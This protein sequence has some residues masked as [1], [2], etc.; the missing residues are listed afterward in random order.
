M[1]GESIPQVTTTACRHAGRDGRGDVAA[2]PRA[3][4]PSPE[5]DWSMSTHAFMERPL[6]IRISR[7]IVVH[8]RLRGSLRQPL[9]I[10]VHGLTGNMDEH[11]FYNG[12]RYLARHGIASYRFNLYDWPDGTRKLHAC[13]LHT[14][15]SDLDRVVAYFR[16]R[17]VRRIIVVGHSYGGPTIL[18]SRAMDF[19]GV[20]LW[21]PSYN[22]RRSWSSARYIRPIQRYMMRW[23]YEV[24]V[25]KA[26]VKQA[27]ALRSTE[28]YAA[29]RLL[30]APVKI[31]AAGEGI[32]VRGCR[33]YFASAHAPKSFVNIPGA[34]H[35]FDEPGV[36]ERLLAETLQWVRRCAR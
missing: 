9:V 7:R 32:L 13:T 35:N 23:A 29:I 34:G 21:D 26:M 5:A 11:I 15:A 1:R 36:E 17:G 25:G 4:S 14:H 20:V 22:L 6:R 12:A 19:D 24:L 10:F 27:R 2:S 8:G 31:I 33:R 3:R 16:N 28:L 18:L 30:N